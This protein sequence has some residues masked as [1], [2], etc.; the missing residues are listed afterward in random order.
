MILDD[1]GRP[2][3]RNRTAL[4][5]SIS[6]TALLRQ[7]DG[8][9]AL[10]AKVAEVIGEP[11]EDVW[12]KTRL[13]GSAGRAARAALLQRLAVPAD[14]GHRRGQHRR[15]RCRSWSAARTSP[16]SPPSSPR[17]ASTRSRSAP[18]PP[19]CSATSGRS[20]TRSWP[21]KRRGHAR[22]ARTRP[23]CSAPTWSAA[24]GSSA[25]TTTTCAASPASRRSRSTTRAGSAACC[26]ETQPTA[27]NYLVTSIDAQVQ[28]VAEKQLKAAIMRART[29]GDIN[30]GFAK[31]QGRLRRRVVMDVRDRRD[32]RDGQ[33]ADVRPERLGRR[34]Q[35]QGLQVD[36]R[37]R[38]TTTRTSPRAFQGQ[39]AP[40]STFKVV[41]L[42][43][44][45]KAGYSL[46]GTYDCPSA[47]PI[48]GHAQG[49]YE[50]RGLRRRSRSRRAI[51]VSCDTIFYRF[52]Y[53]TWL[54]DGRL[55]AEE[56][57]QGPVTEMAKAFG[58][59]K[60]TGIDLPSESDGRI[61]DRAWK[62]AYWKANKDFYCAKA[63]TGYPEVARK[64]PEPR[65]V[66]D[67][68]G[69]GELRRRLRL[70]RR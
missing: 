49:N 25:S 57:R 26:R 7:Q 62:Q 21:R 40:G 30:K 39:F 3:A 51:E 56:E 67:A 60:P 44:A 12:D 28:A 58:L 5:V 11:A 13:C 6:R 41:S 47:Y 69:Q 68:A 4:V 24:P 9:R 45:V 37:A 17:C 59:G 33:L 54:R 18:T 50:S 23:S 43:A 70:P 15:W 53:E 29:A 27:G 8:G 42:P 16:A 38:R 19:T 61:A 52:A 48:G 46:N 63:K 31:L 10:V 34:H 14:P 20:P 55:H 32:R 66:P 65:R 22:G 36:H 2:L 35:Q 1:R 64:R